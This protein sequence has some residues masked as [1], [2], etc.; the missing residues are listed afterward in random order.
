MSENVVGR[1][2]WDASGERIYETGVNH[3]VLYPKNLTGS[4]VT[5]Q[6]GGYNNGVAWNGITSVNE[7]PSGGE[8]NP[9]YADNIKYLNLI[10]KEEFGGT[11]EAYTYP[12]EFAQCDG[13]AQPVPGFYVG[14][15]RRKEFGFSYRTEVGNDE[16][17]NDY[18][19]K[20]H[21]VYGALASPSGKQYNTINE[22][23]EAIQ[24][25]W[26]F[27]TTPVAVDG[28]SD[29]SPVAHLIIDSTKC[30]S[31]KLTALED[32]LY[33]K[34]AVAADAQNNIEAVDA[35]APRL[36]MPKEVYE[37]MTAE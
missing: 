16:Q 28:H 33:G 4:A 8:A 19:Y 15:Q 24:F 17:G 3:G 11:I 18:G 25:S 31:E 35:I 6:N 14:Q 32:I 21:L 9:L 5:Q 27:T 2:V 13:S 26:E 23:P 7:N 29:L 34:D 37:L 20:I 30:D 10:S 12:D 1:I 22:S 36:P